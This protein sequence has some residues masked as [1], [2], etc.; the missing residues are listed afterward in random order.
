MIDLVNAPPPNSIQNLKA[1]TELLYAALHTRKW[2]TVL[3]AA[4]M[5]E[6]SIAAI[7]PEEPNNAN[8]SS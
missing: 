6:E 3:I 4:D 2:L 5:L 8:G 7:E 1:I